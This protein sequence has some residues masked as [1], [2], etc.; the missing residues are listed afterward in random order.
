MQAP[1]MVCVAP[2]HPK[3]G[4]HGFWVLHE[5]PLVPGTS[6]KLVMETHSWPRSQFVIAHELPAIGALPHVPQMLV[7]L[8]LQ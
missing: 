4:P 3:S 7:L 6:H 5:A 1:I 8:L 2:T